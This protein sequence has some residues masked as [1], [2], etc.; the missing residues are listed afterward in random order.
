MGFSL[1]E[2]GGGAERVGG[3]LL[4]VVHHVI[5]IPEW[6]EV[7]TTAKASECVFVCHLASLKKSQVV[8]HLRVIS[9]G[10]YKS[11]RRGKRG[12]PMRP[13]A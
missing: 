6:P 2:G 10:C 4:D 11:L 13:H 12:G 8:F 9:C 1:G 5:S 3:G 7:T